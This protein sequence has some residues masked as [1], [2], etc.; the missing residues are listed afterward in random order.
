MD[1]QVTTTEQEVQ[2]A[3]DYI[4]DRGATG[5]AVASLCTPPVD[6]NSKDEVQTETGVSSSHSSEKIETQLTEKEKEK[7]KCDVCGKMI[8]RKNMSCH[9]KTIACTSKKIASTTIIVNPENSL[10]SSSS[11]S[12]SSSSSGAETTTKNKDVGVK[13][14]FDAIDEKLDFLLEMVGEL[15]T[16]ILVDDE[17]GSDSEESDTEEKKRDY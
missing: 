14:R 11:F 10:S 8:V 15:I 7:I 12:S 17:E 1:N 6:P 13:V 5:D 3:I 2:K 16:T 9:K 4:C